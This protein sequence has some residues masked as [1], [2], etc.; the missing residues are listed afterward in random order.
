MRKTL[1]AL[2]GILTMAVAFAQTNEPI[3]QPQYTAIVTPPKAA[4]IVQAQSVLNDAFIGSLVVKQEKNRIAFTG[5][6]PQW[7]GSKPVKGWV[8]NDLIIHYE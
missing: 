6:S 3:K 8:G 7:Q 1:L 5:I 4:T 2:F